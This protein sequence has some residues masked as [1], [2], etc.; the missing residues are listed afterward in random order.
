MEAVPSLD[1]DLLLLPLLIGLFEVPEVENTP[2]PEA[3]PSPILLQ[4]QQ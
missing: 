1:L 4:E 2:L 3:L